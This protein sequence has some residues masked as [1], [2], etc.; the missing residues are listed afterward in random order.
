MAEQDIVYKGYLDW[1][2]LIDDVAN[3]K[4]LLEKNLVL[5]SAPSFIAGVADCLKMYYTE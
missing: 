2:N 4:R 5:P 3:Q 1:A